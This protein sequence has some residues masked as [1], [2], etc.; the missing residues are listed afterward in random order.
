MLT[1][2]TQKLHA[3]QDNKLY[4]LGCSFL[5]GG[6][7]F[8]KEAVKVERKKIFLYK[9]HEMIFF[10]QY[11]CPHQPYIISKPYWMSLAV[12]SSPENLFLVG[13]LVKDSCKSHW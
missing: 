7:N 12:F 11:S 13:L 3:Q 1:L 8:S 6:V 4:F 2:L 9:N 5:F 10:L